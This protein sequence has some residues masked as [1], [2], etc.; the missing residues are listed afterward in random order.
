[1]P[2]LVAANSK[3][4]CGKSTSALILGTTLAQRGATVRI[5]DAD[6]QGT[7]ARWGRAGASKYHQ[8]VV[9]P[10]P[11]AD[12][13]DLIDELASEVQFVLIDVQGAATQEIAAAMSRADLVLIPMQ[14]KT[15]DADETARAIQLLRSQ[16][17]LFRRSIAHG[18]VFMRTNPAIATR[19]EKAIRESIEGAGIP[20]FKTA[21]HERTAFSQM[22]AQRLAVDELS[23]SEVNGLEVARANAIAFAGEV[24]ETL[25]RGVVQ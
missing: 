11:S 9:T 2:T 22:F 17:K 13:T 8:I 7:L 16:E 6:P 24:I 19:E 5:I 18:I 21:L 15:A 1:M 14:G 10:K 25:Q 20:C 12:L 3:G 23:A 4:G